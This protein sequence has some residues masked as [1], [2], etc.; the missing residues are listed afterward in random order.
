M[1]VFELRLSRILLI[2]TSVSWLRISSSFVLDDE[3]A[4]VCIVCPLCLV[5]L[6]AKIELM[7]AKKLFK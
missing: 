2:S 7:L 4:C 3:V 5:I 6:F 1:L